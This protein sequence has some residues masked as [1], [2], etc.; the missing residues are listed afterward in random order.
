MAAAPYS[1]IAFSFKS[2]RC[3][4]PWPTR[5][6]ATWAVPSSANAHLAKTHRTKGAG[7]VG[8]LIG[9][10]PSFLVG[11]ST[12][13]FLSTPSALPTAR[14]PSLPIRLRLRSSTS[15]PGASPRS[16]VA[17]RAPQPSP[18]RPFDARLKRFRAP[19]PPALWHQLKPRRRHLSNRGRPTGC[20]NS[21]AGSVLGDDVR[22]FFWDARGAAGSSGTRR[23]F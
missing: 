12:G 15:R 13:T 4:V 7:S 16:S 20:P 18:D 14:P 10:G 11:E 6:M 1:P 22:T 19:P 5:P 17:Q 21:T 23:R 8:C 2:N 3:S 9:R